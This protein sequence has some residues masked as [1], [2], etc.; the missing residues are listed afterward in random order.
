MISYLQQI[1]LRCYW[2]Q[3]QK[4][5]QFVQIHRLHEWFLNPNEHTKLIVR[6]DGE[7]LRQLGM[8][9]C[10]TLDQNSHD[11]TNDFNTKG[12][13][14]ISKS[15][16]SWVFSNYLWT[17]D[18]IATYTAANGSNTLNKTDT[19]FQCL[20]VEKILWEFLSFWSL[21]MQSHPLVWCHASET[22]VV[23]CEERFTKPFLLLYRQVKL[24]F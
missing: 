14:V 19:F 23:W 10:I 16:K 6:T 21:E 4:L 12:K 18:K 1:H 20:A 24:A 2:H 7:G 5:L 11:S 15:S 22:Y 8:N 9:C 17:R 3:H 13:S